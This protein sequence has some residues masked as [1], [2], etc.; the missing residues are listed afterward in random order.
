MH[1]NGNGHQTREKKMITSNYD[2]AE[3][4]QYHNRI[5]SNCDKLAS[6]RNRKSDQSIKYFALC[7]WQY[8]LQSRVSIGDHAEA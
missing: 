1:Q 6:E 3:E 5:K 7:Y 8:K 2:I 4:C